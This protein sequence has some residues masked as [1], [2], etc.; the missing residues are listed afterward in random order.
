MVVPSFR[1]VVSWE[2][3][4]TANFRHRAWFTG[5]NNLSSLIVGSSIVQAVVFMRSRRW[6]HMILLHSLLALYFVTFLFFLVR[7]LFPFW[8]CLRSP[9]SMFSVS[10]LGFLGVPS[11]MAELE[12][13]EIA[14]RENPMNL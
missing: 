5:K 6:L 14:L 13:A 3:W 1:V 8:L 11:P 4:L 9:K 2:I 12:S 10:S 7:S